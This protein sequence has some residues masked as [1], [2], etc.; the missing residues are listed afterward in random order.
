MMSIAIVPNIR[1]ATFRSRR[2]LRT[3]TAYPTGVNLAAKNKKAGVRSP[4]FGLPIG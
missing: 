3:V 2:F 1:I 4:A